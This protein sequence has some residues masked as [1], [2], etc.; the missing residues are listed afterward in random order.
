VFRY[1]DITPLLHFS[2]HG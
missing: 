2:Y 1:A